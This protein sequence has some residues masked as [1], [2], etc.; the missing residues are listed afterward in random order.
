M[1]LNDQQAVALQKWISGMNVKVTAVPGAGKSRVMLESCKSFSD[2]L[3]LILLITTCVKRPI[4]D[5]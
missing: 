1:V 4:Q 3:I 5:S 2:G